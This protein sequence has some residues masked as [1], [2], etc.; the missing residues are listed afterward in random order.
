[1]LFVSAET[2]IMRNEV[3]PG[4]IL[5]YVTVRVSLFFLI[6]VLGGCT[7]APKSE[8][9]EQRSAGTTPAAPAD[10]RH[11]LVAFGDSLTAGF[12]AEPGA[13]FPDYLQKLIDAKHYHWRVINAG[14]S[15][16]TST[17][18]LARLPGILE[19]K[20]EMVILEL[21]AN[22]GLRGIPVD[23]TRSNLEQIIQTLRDG[24][25]KV[26]LAGMTLP[27]NY[28]PDYIRPFE[29]VFTDLA[30]EYKLTLIPFLLQGVGGNA[31]L[32]QRDGLHPTAEGNRRVAL[33]VMRVIEPLLLP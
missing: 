31:S 24:G 4:D 19:A 23:A 3:G 6:F 26:V 30:A 15:G 25:V 27:P 16:D 10:T 29:R 17:G 14:V 32:M 33:N 11:R 8:P 13:S 12:G 9:P 22:D 2:L 18:G 5:Y 7:V 20:P 21:G 28:G 1:M